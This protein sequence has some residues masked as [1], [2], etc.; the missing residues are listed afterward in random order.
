MR[1]NFANPLLPRTITDRIVWGGL[2]IGAVAIVAALAEFW[3]ANPGY[4]DRFLILL[5]AGYA[6][7]T[8]APTWLAI[9]ARPRPFAGLVLVVIGGVLFPIGYFLF[10]QIG[11]RTLVL[12]WLTGSL[13]LVSGGYVLVRYGVRQLWAAAFPLLFPLFALPIPLRVLNPLQGGL[14]EITTTLAHLSLSALG[15]AVSREEFVLALP[16]GKLLV[17]EACSGVRSF[18]ALTALAAF[19]AFLRGFGFG[20]GA[21]L[22]LLSVPIVAAVNVLRVIL[23]GLIQEGIGPEYIQGD[24]HDGLGFV[25]VLVGLALILGTAALLGTKTEPDPAPEQVGAGRGVVRSGAWV[26]VGL[27][28]LGVVATGAAAWFGRMTTEEAATTAPIA[29]INTTLGPWTGEDLP[30]PP[31]VSDQLAP[32]QAVYRAYTNNFGLRAHVWVFHWTTGAAIKGYHHPDVCWSSR[33]FAAAEQWIEPITLETGAT[34]PV[35]AREFRQG[36]TRQI[37]LYWTQEGQR[38]WTADDERAAASDA[39]SVW[40]GQ[41]WVGDLLGVRSAPPGSRITVL[42]AVP[43]A[44]PAA[45][46]ATNDLTRRVA[47]EVYRTCPWAMP[48]PH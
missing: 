26:A 33:G 11:P 37:I 17:E 4:A 20:R 10:Q 6:A 24:W 29:E 27:I 8:L 45:R 1:M 13:I 35:T 38:V 28:G 16:G 7:Y 46:T 32:D 30:I 19:V 44:G 31:V 14:Q 47:A 40:H 36:K 48:R 9:P 22:V 3:G 21:I 5:G 12:W 2:A 42:V 23:S 41:H 34:V 18:T 39:L 15:L 43:S 25:M